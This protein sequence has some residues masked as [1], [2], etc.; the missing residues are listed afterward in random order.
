M[1]IVT[2]YF[3]VKRLSG[4][5]FIGE[6]SLRHRV[7][8]QAEYMDC[9]RRNAAHAE[10][11]ALHIL[12]QGADAYRHFRAHV[13]EDEGFFPSKEM[14]RKIIPVLRDEVQPT[15]ADLFQH[16]NQL[17]RG[18][19]T[20]ICNADVYLPQ[21]G[22]SVQ[23]LRKLFDGNPDRH[24]AVA[25]TRYESEHRGDAPLIED[26]RGSHDA[27]IIRPPTEAAFIEGVRHPQNCYKAENIVLYELQRH[28]YVVVNPCRSFMIV[29]R[30]A[31]DLRQWLPAVDE[32]RYARAPPCT[33]AEALDLIGQRDC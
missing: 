23:E 2:S 27:F 5:V 16:A 33:M 28:G 20:M 9:L 22:A 1:N 25:L 17:L 32:E 12:V 14:R 19:L 13:L 15:Y 21:A 6:A 3:M 8:R 30:H 29:H 4:S 24:V 31:A 10:V 26:Y 18:E 11:A 7:A